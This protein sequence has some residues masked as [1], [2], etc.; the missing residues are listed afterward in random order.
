MLNMYSDTNAG[1]KKCPMS[2][3]ST[4]GVSVDSDKKDD[5]DVKTIRSESKMLSYDDTLVN[6]K[7]IGQ[8]KED[9]KLRIY[10]SALDI[11]TRYAQSAMRAFCGDSRYSTIEFIAA[12]V[13]SASKHSAELLDGL[14]DTPD[15]KDLTHKLSNITGD[16]NACL[17]GLEKLKITYRDD[18][19]FR[20]K[21]EVIADKIRVI[22]NDNMD[23]KRKY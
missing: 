14:E 21:I 10:N 22:T 7:L 1:S 11:D 19:V 6:L 16:L 9:Q 13:D 2:P 20:S 4:T 15:D 12:L 3:I 17:N 18:H 8:L 5:D 23:I